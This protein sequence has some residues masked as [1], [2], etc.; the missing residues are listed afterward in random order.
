M[1]VNQSDS[2]LIKPLYNFKA[3]DM[4]SDEAVFSDQNDLEWPFDKLDSLIFFYKNSLQNKA[5]KIQQK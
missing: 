2:C 4:R 3:C 1:T 5:T